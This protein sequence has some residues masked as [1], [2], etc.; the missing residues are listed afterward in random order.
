MKRKPDWAV[1]LL[2]F[3]DEA[4]LRPY[5][6]G[7]HDC[8]I[9]TCDAVLAMTGTDPAAPFRGHYH[10]RSTAYRA[11]QAFAGGGIRES[12]EKIAGTHGCP[13]VPVAKARRGDVV[14]LEGGNGPTLGIIDLMGFNILSVV[15]VGYT[16]MP[17]AKGVAAWQIP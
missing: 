2:E 1:R 7:V 6:W 3:L 12:A 4:T 15:S 17:L 11:L 5:A 13:G 16:A 14:L 9:F 10:D 8:C